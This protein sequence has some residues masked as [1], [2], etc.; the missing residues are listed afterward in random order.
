MGP[1]HVLSESVKNS[2]LLLL[3]AKSE[4]NK[5]TFL[6]YQKPTNQRTPGPLP[7]PATRVTPSE[8]EIKHKLSDALR[9][10]VIHGSRFGEH[11]RVWGPVFLEF[12]VLPGHVTLLSPK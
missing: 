3:L 1:G 8:S 4:S 6:F 12:L 2:A 7:I 5:D 11:S 10:S 9:S